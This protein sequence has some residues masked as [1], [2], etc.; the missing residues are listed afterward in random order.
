VA[1]SPPPRRWIIAA[2]CAAIGLGL[3]YSEHL[4]VMG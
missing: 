2:I 3:F 1:A 4:A